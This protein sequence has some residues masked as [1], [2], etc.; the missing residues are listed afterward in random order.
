MSICELFPSRFFSPSLS[1]FLR[2]EMGR[3][4]TPNGNYVFVWHLCCDALLHGALKGKWTINKTQLIPRNLRQDESN[5]GIGF[6]FLVMSWLKSCSCEFVWRR[7]WEGREVSRT[8]KAR[9][10]YWCHLWEA[11]MLS[12]QNFTRNIW[13]ESKLRCFEHKGF[14][15]LRLGSIFF[16]L[17]LTF[18]FLFEITV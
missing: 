6:A 17:E 7:E 10:S 1:Q 5:E 4:S 9:F 8:L 16:R 2:W 14:L 13:T 18:I 12:K 15:I 11:V 3:I